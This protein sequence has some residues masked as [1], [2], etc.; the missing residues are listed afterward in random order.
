MSSKSIINILFFLVVLFSLSACKTSNL[1]FYNKLNN[2]SVGPYIYF[3]EGIKSRL[4]GNYQQAIQLQNKS[5]EI[6][7]TNSATYYELSL[8]F[9]SLQDNSNA[10]NTHCELSKEIGYVQIQG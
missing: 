8:S 9:A 10:E 7:S 2:S 1:L 6:D 4:I 5:I 3:Y